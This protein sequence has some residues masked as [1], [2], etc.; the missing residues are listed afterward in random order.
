MDC[1]FEECTSLTNVQIGPCLEAINR[2][3]FARCTAL[4]SVAIADGA[5]KDPERV[6][7]YVFS[8]CNSLESVVV[9]AYVPYDDEDWFGDKLPD[10]M[11]LT[12]VGDTDVM[13]CIEVSNLNDFKLD[14]SIVK[15][16]RT[17]AID[18]YVG[19][20]ICSP[21]TGET[22]VML[23]DSET[24]EKVIVRIYS[25]G[26]KRW[27]SVRPKGYH[28]KSLECYSTQRDAKGSKYWPVFSAL[29]A[30]GRKE[31]SAIRD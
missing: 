25:R 27:Y 5:L 20:R 4:K 26:A 29:L 10:G 14:E 24:R 1:A 17:E 22:R 28:T 11:A 13:P 23:M 15:S 6:G 12:E 2:S 18:V 8:G 21:A 16:R 9:P 31:A 7:S 3:A 19:C 30:Y